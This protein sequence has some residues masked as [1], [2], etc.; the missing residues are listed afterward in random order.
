MQTVLFEDARRRSSFRKVSSLNDFAWVSQVDF[1]REA[2]GK[3]LNVMGCQDYWPK[4][5]N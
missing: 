3:S 4:R 2:S 1:G 5:L